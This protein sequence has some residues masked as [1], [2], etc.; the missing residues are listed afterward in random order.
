MRTVSQ[1]GHSKLIEWE[2]AGELNRVILPTDA[3]DTNL[4]IPY[5]LP[6]AEMLSDYLPEEMAS[7]IESSLHKNGIWTY[8]DLK[9]RPDAALGAIQAAYGVDLA[10]LLVLSKHYGG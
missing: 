6:F 4:G 7:R 1:K 5:G 9:Q 10:R 3:N 8:E 2:E